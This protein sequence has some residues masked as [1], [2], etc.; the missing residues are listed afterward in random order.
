M[1]LALHG[2]TETDVVW[3]E[4]L[5]PHFPNLK[6]PLLPGHGWKPCTTSTT[7]VGTAAEFIA[8]I[9]ANEPI[10][11]LGYSMGGRLAIRVALEN[12]QRIR[13]VVLISCNPGIADQAERIDRRR[14]DEH[15]AQIL[16]EDG[17]GPFVAWW[18]SNPTLR[19]AKPFSRAMQE[20]LR[21]MRLNHEPCG[22]AWSLRTL[23]S[24]SDEGN[25]WPRLGELRMPVLLASGEADSKYHQIMG[26]MAKHI[27]GARHEVIAAAGHAIHREQ[28]NQLVALIRGFLA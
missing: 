11:L 7:M 8:N 4:L 13:R 9:P 15:L 6:C 17:I 24:C 16:E 18:Q 22:L 25:M 1:L 5:S 19:P 20:S 21:C 14:R 27:P 23:G 26:E 12:P 10:D 3:Q 28:A 2:F